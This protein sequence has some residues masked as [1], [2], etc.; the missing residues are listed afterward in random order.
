MKTQVLLVL[1][2]TTA[3]HALAGESGKKTVAPPEEDR[4]KF[5]L[6]APGWF[7]GLSGDV[8]LYGIIENT[9]INASDLYRHADMLASFRGEVSK[10]RF[11][12][13]GDFLY[14]SLSD[15]VGTNTVVK[16]LDVQLDYLLSDLGL[17]WRV[18]DGPRGWLDVTAG[19]RYTNMYQKLVTQPNSTQ[20]DS[21]AGDLV[22]EI[23]ERLRGALAD[24]GIGGIIAEQ[25][26]DSA[27]VA[28][29]RKQML[30][31]AALRGRDGVRFRRIAERII[32]ERR[33][34]LQAAVQAADTAVG[35]AKAEAE[36]RVDEIKREISEKIARSLEKGLKAE[37]SRVDD[38]FD[39][40]IGLRGRYNFT[41][42]F[43]FFAK[44]DIGGF[45]VGSDFTWQAEGAFGYEL[46]ESIYA[47]LGYRALSVNYEGDGLTYDMITHGAQLTV[48]VAF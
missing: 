29:H 15:G 14:M 33:A 9:D 22:D 4:W 12:L 27:L 38:W 10:G 5:A 37:K 31:I 46:T 1:A 25:L 44:G 42:R 26:T 3:S 23:G 48:G 24:S 36:G 11:G 16:K 2:V 40:Y 6:S 30:P 45:G 7:T 43:Y 17:R 20:I 39:P 32:R 13:M 28:D 34:E 8:G 19:V 21:F 35:A 41:D 18:L 47:E